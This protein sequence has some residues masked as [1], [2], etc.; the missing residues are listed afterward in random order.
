MKPKNFIRYEP[1][2][3]SRN[4]KNFGKVVINKY[5]NGSQK[6]RPKHQQKEKNQNQII[7]NDKIGNYEHQ[8]CNNG[9]TLKDYDELRNNYYKDQIALNEKW[10]NIKDTVYNEI[11]KQH[12]YSEEKC[13]NCN[14][15]AKFFCNNC[16]PQAFFCEDCNILFHKFVNIYHQQVNIFIPTQLIQKPIKLMPICGNNCVH[17]TLNLDVINLQG[18][19]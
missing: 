17:E 11:L 6:F 15:N 14:K 7:D 19:Y 2:T 9:N 5:A 12:S 8:F 4:K 18:I 3:I 10:E 1:Y 16:G 13:I